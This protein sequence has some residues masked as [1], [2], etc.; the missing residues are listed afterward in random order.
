MLSLFLIFALNSCVSIEKRF[1]KGKEME[2]QGR[3]EEAAR[4][5][6]KVLEK[7]PTWEEVRQRLENVG[8]QTVEIY[9]KQ[10]YA[11]KSSGSYEDAVEVLGRI[12]DLRSRTDN[13]GV[14]LPVP[15]DY[16]LFHQEMTAAAI[17]SL[18]AQGETAEQT[19]DWAEAIRKYERLKRL[20]PLSPDQ[21]Q[22]ADQAR[23]RIYTKWADQ[24]LAQDYFQAAF[25]HA[26]MA[27][28]IFGPDSETSLSALKIQQ[29]ALDLGTK[30]VA[31]LPFWSSERASEET[32]RGLARELYDVLVYEYMSEPL[33]FIVP[34]E[35]GQIHREIRRLRLRDR[36]I[37]RQMAVRIGQNLGT[38]L[39]VT[40]MIE[41][42]LEEEN[43]LREEEHEARFKSDKTKYATYIEQKYNL[44][45]TAKVRFQIIDSMMRRIL[46]E[47][48]VRSEVSD[49]FRLG[50]YEGDYTDLDLSRSERR[51]F[52]RDRL[53]RSEQELVDR[54][55]DKLAERLAE[56]IYNKTLQQI[57]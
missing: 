57:S 28:D 56:K 47:D 39:V 45:F 18:F 25:N 10:A 23:A 52:D 12:D 11:Y 51:L 30:I 13:V 53:R 7:D 20:Y 36:E 2:N 33:P 32:P 48:T 9:L 3:F 50:I 41:V 54:L 38:D 19:G 29:A 49:Q 14:S 40:G 42:F 15:D 37:T 4:S 8:T 22:K 44:K 16:E 17:D 24:D 27:I 55:I 46:D 34:I 6:I 35:P 43:I 5:Y 1:E 26:Q 21:V 31:V